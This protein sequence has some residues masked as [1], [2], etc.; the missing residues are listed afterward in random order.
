M[1]IASMTGFARV[2]GGDG[3]LSWTWEARSVNGRTLDVRVRLAQALAATPD[4]WETLA[5]DAMKAKLARGTVQVSLQLRRAAEDTGLRLN[6]ARLRAF[7]VE[8]ARLARLGLAAP[9]RADGLLALRGVL[10][11]AGDP[12]AAGAPG[13]MTETARAAL[14]ADMAA[15][16]DR[17]ATACLAEGAALGTALD[18][19]LEHIEH[20]HREAT[21]AAADLPEALRARLQARLAALIQDA[22]PPERLAQ[23]AAILAVKADVREELDRLAAHIAAARGH[24]A[25]GGAVGRKLDFL[26]QEFMRESNTLC[27]KSADMEITRVGLA[28]KAAVEQFR[29]Q[30][31]NVA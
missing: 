21:A 25:Q 15:L 27:A 24:L 14:K 3:P 29:E 6:R 7:A 11:A 16:A 13:G 9:A 1:A 8:A 26:A 2:D 17:L 23:E 10:E 31:Q 5:R 30:V 12:D 28:L 22:V 20:L 4:P 19:V 18:R